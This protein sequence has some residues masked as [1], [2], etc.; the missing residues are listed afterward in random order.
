MSVVQ[1]PLDICKGSEVVIEPITYVILNHGRFGE[2]LIKSAELIAG[3]TEH[4]RAVS[5]LS[6]MS[7]EEYYE[8]VR[9]YMA[10]LKGEILVLADLYG[11]TPSNVGMMLQREF[12]LHVICGVNLPMLIEL[13]LKRS[14]EACSVQELMEAGLAAARA[15]IIQPDQIAFEEI[16]GEE[17]VRN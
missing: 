1:R 12:S 13:I 11:G 10:T 9:A 14:N 16:E 7:I 5:L 2:E 15:S 17:H 6:G 4:I 8:E 3:K